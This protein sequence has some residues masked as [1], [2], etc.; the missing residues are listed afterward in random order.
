MSGADD[1]R[2]LR[3]QELNRFARVVAQVLAIDVGPLY[4]AANASRRR[5]T[6]FTRRD[7]TS[8]ETWGYDVARF[9]V[10]TID[11]PVGAFPA[12]AREVDITIDLNLGGFCDDSDA[13]DPLFLLTVDIVAEA[14]ASPT[15]AVSAWHLDRHPDGGSPSPEAHPIYHFQYG[16]R[17]ITTRIGFD[18]GHTLLLEPPRVAHPPLDAILAADFVVSNYFP[19]SWDQLRRAPEYVD[20][21]AQ[22]QHRFW[23]PYAL[24]SARHPRWAPTASGP[25]PSWMARDVWPQILPRRGI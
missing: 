19:D 17:R 11:A 3:S 1:F 9:R 7:G 6:P 4:A 16:G 25:S 12:H 8:W 22:A 15:R 23:R 10:G 21:V 14:S 20:L 18:F 2:Q 5:R 24:A 13:H